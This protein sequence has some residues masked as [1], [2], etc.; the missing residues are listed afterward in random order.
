MTLRKSKYVCFDCRTSKPQT[1]LVCNSNTGAGIRDQKD[2]R[3]KGLSNGHHRYMKRENEDSLPICQ[4]CG[5]EMSELP[6]NLPTPRKS[7][8]KGW[9]QYESSNMHG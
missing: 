3:Y 6:S 9:R 4:E 5:G 2:P 8:D 1:N 7:D